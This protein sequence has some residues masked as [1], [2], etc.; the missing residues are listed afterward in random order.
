MIPFAFDFPLI[1]FKNKLYIY[2][3]MHYANICI[4][5]FFFKF[6][7]NCKIQLVQLW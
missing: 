2:G 7:N 6:L 4:N 5:L 3:V 1:F